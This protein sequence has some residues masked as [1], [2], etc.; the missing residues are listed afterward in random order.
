MLDIALEKIFYHLPDFTFIQFSLTFLVAFL[1]G[2]IRG[3]TGFAGALLLLPGFVFIMGPLAAL[4]VVVVSGMIGQLSILPNAIK[5]AQKKIV[6]FYGIGIF[7]GVYL[8]LSFFFKREL[9]DIT[10]FMGIF[11]II[12]TIILIAGWKYKGNVNSITSV[13]FG[14]SIGFFAGFFGVP[15]G[16][17]TGLFFLSQKENIKIIHAN[18]QCTVIL[19]VLAFFTYFYF[20]DGYKEEFLVLGLIMSIP[21]ALGLKT[22]QLLF[23]FL[24][25]RIFR[26]ITYSCLIILGAL[27]S[28]ESYS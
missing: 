28:I 2:L 1:G 18:I 17:L 26:P 22:G 20:V 7:A 27:L 6:S 19:T 8:G 16:P 12:A 9:S 25:E 11:I 5:N 23:N 13:S 3:Y 4:N 15:T 14:G 21:L 10:F 24:P